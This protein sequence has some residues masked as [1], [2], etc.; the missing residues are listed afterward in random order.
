VFSFDE[1]S[2][3]VSLSAAAASVATASLAQSAAQADE[4][5]Y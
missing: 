3:I 2:Q 4:G 1:R 5:G